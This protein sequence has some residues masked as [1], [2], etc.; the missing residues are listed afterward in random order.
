MLQSRLE[1]GLLVFCMK[2]LLHIV[3]NVMRID[4]WRGSNVA[5]VSAVCLQCREMRGSQTA[6][7]ISLVAVNLLWRR[8]HLH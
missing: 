5:N 3:R 8:V 6:L 2:R 7:V 1:T 4:V